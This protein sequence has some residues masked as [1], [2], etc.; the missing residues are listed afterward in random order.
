[1]MYKC[2]QEATNISSFGCEGSYDSEKGTF[3]SGV[4]VTSGW[5]LVLLVGLLSSVVCQL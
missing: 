5:G 3:S 1:M 2:L 4:R